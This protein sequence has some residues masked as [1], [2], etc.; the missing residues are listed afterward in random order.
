MKTIHEQKEFN[1]E[2][3]NIKKQKQ[4]TETLPEEHSDSAEE[5]NRELQQQT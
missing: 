2:I 4:K 1:K 3:E 5:F